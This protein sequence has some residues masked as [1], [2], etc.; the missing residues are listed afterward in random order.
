VLA[1][2]DGF[3]GA[4]GSRRTYKLS[5][6]RRRSLRRRPWQGRELVLDR[7]LAAAIDNRSSPHAD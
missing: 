3:Q 5:C 6:S 1:K 4:A 7:V 2:P